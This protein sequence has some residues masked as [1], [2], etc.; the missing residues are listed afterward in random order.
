MGQ[1]R[2]GALDI[3]NCEHE[4]LRFIGGM[5]KNYELLVYDLTTLVIQFTTS[6][7][8]ALLEENGKDLSNLKVDQ[9]LMATEINFDQPDPVLANVKLFTGAEFWCRSVIVDS[10][11]YL[12]FSRS[13]DNIFKQSN[14]NSIVQFHNMLATIDQTSLRVHEDI[15]QKFCSFFQNIS[16][17]DRVMTYQFDCD[18]NGSVV[19]ETITPDIEVQE[20]RGLSFPASDIP[21]QA[22][23]LFLENRVRVINDVNADANPVFALQDDQNQKIDLGVLKERAVSPVHLKYL[24]N[25]GVKSSLSISIVANSQLWGLVA[26]HNYRGAIYPSQIDIEMC[27]ALCDLLGNA[28][29]HAART[30]QIA[31]YTSVNAVTKEIRR[32]YVQD[33]EVNVVDLF[34]EHE[35]A[36]LNLFE[37]DCCVIKCGTTEIFMGNIDD[38]EQ[39]RFLANGIFESNLMGTDQQFFS[40]NCIDDL[41]IIDQNETATFAGLS[42]LRGSFSDHNIV[43]FRR[44]LPEKTV[45]GGDPKKKVEPNGELTPR[46]SFKAWQSKLANRSADWDESANEGMRTILECFSDGVHLYEMHHAHLKVKSALDDANTSQNKLLYQSLHDELTG[47]PNRRY[48]SQYLRDIDPT[49]TVALIRIDLDRFKSINDTYGHGVGDAVLKSTA[50]SLKLSSP[51]ESFICRLGGDEFLILLNQECD[52]TYLNKLGNYIIDCMKDIEIPDN[53]AIRISCSVGIALKKKQDF[54]LDKYITFADEALYKSKQNGRGIVS[55]ISDSEAE[56]VDYR[57]KLGAEIRAGLENNE[58]YYEYQP[59]FASFSRK[60]A[61]AEAL[62]RWRRAGGKKFYPDQF[63]KNAEIE[64]TI[65]DI[66][67]LVFLDALKAK[68]KLIENGIMVNKVSVNLS[69]SRLRSKSFLDLVTG[70]PDIRKHISFEILEGINL[71]ALDEVMADALQKLK[72]A[73]VSLYLDDFGTGYTSILSLVSFSPEIIKIDK[74]LV[75]PATG[76]QAA[77]NL[78]KSIVDLSNSLSIK[79]IAEGI[80]TVQHADL[81][82]NLGIDF[83]Q[84]YYFSKPARIEEICTKFGTSV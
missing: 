51:S 80:E 34:K 3:E 38:S 45:W 46:N 82:E 64:G 29:T 8:K 16:G 66:E 49:N 74:K 26:C 20:F 76:N 39:A 10:I 52:Q 1:M 23:E 58:F 50:V 42:V 2:F 83:M 54:D 33:P 43:M 41:T 31:Y 6:G 67:Q 56:N 17:F 12:C 13:A 57:S 24:A 28:L 27:R 25:M 78:L 59:I 15:L 81:A 30:R 36:L 79:T 60:I 37:I 68:R 19:A 14:F 18:W 21:R 61:S 71:D 84:G 32:K 55:I 72:E 22:R 47:L 62:L 35:E 48:L 44:N 7:L 40:T 75:I 5:Q 4:P 73:D 77:Y 11:C 63:L 70:S 53:R 65:D 9:L 69:A